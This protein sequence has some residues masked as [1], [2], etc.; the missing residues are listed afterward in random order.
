MKTFRTFK[1]GLL[2]SS[3]LAVPFIQSAP[4]SVTL[5]QVSATGAFALDRTTGDLYVGAGVANGTGSIT[6]FT[7]HNSD[8]S[9]PTTTGVAIAGHGANSSIVPL[10]A[11]SY[12]G[13]T[14]RLVFTVGTTTA[15]D[16]QKKVMASQADGTN[17]IKSAILKDAGGNNI[18]DGGVVALATNGSAVFAAVADGGTDWGLLLGTDRG[19]NVGALGGTTGALTLAATSNAVPVLVSAADNGTRHG[20]T[21]IAVLTVGELPVLHWDET[22]SRLYVGGQLTTAAVAANMAISVLVAKSTNADGNLTFLATVG[23]TA[24]FD[25]A[26][27]AT[28]IVFAAATGA[29]AARVAKAY[30]LGVMHTSTGHAY[31]IINGGSGAALADLKN[32][33]YA[34]PLVKGLGTDADGTF[35]KSELTTPTFNI[36]ASA[37]T[38]IP[39][40]TDAHALVG[41]GVLPFAAT[42]G[43]KMQVIGDTIY[44]STSTADNAGTVEAGLFYST[45]EFNENGKVI[46]WSRWARACPAELGTSDTNGALFNFRVNPRNGKVWTA[47]GSNAAIIKVSTWGEETAATELASA[48]NAILTD[49]CTAIGVF[50]RSTV[51][52]GNNV[53][54]RLSLFGGNEKVVFTRQSTTQVDPAGNYSA[55]TSE[56]NPT[57]ATANGATTFLSTTLPAGAGY[58]TALGGTNH[59]GTA[60]VNTFYFLAGTTEGLYAYAKT[61][62]AGAT[63]DY[64]TA[65]N[66][67]HLDGTAF[68][69]A[70]FFLAGNA[71]SWQAVTSVTGHIKKIKTSDAGTFILARDIGTDGTIIDTLYRYSGVNT[72]VAA[73]SAAVVTIAQSG[74]SAT[75][76]DL[77]L[78]TQIYDFEI[79]N[80]LTA[81]TGSQIILATNN[82]LYQSKT[83]HATGVVAATNQATALWTPIG[84]KVGNKDTRGQMFTGIFAKGKTNL[85]TTFHAISLK[86]NSNNTRTYNFRDLDQFVCSDD[87]NGATGNNV[88]TGLSFSHYLS[89]STTTFLRTN[90]ILDYWTDGVRR[91]MLATPT[92]TTGTT[93]LYIWPYQVGTDAWNITDPVAKISATALADKTLYC[94]NLL[95]D[96][97]LA[98]GTSTGIV[99]L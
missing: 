88:R 26:D 6:K 37:A 60:D 53:G 20:K 25:N 79:I 40:N 22:L 48:V 50:D 99:L 96:G 34:L 84:E 64:A 71:N 46:R 67:H 80:G 62:G 68:T 9:A 28:R 87:D 93:G 61:A 75:S 69:L 11:L 16:D 33:V 41:A 12:S 30:N 8:G 10:L 92:D 17:T 56:E 77:T 89:D 23:N 29:G 70:S 65:D 39:V 52:W 97:H 91:F 49:G 74:V 43:T 36:Q 63:L 98:V 35:A 2:L 59:V 85:T 51:N 81:G 47:Q 38:D 73:L 95:P 72:T 57:G 14:P 3:F 31:L 32:Q 54:S 18:F 86:D 66:L 13:T 15:A 24:A 76:S 19:I 45:P 58:V 55:L 78:A 1:L 82:G 94:I 42:S 21:G 44:V 27:V 4:D 90:R 7:A 5:A 83:D